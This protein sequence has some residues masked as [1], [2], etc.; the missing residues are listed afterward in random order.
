V[1]RISVLFVVLTV[2]ISTLACVTLLGEDLPAAQS[3]ADHEPPPAN[4]FVGSSPSESVSC[5]L[6]TD[7]ILKRN[8]GSPDE[9]ES[10]T[11]DF[12][13]RSENVE[14]TLVTYLVSGDTIFAPYSEDVPANLKDEQHDKPAHQ[15]IWDYFA[16]LI[17]SK[18]R[19]ILALFSI[20]TDGK[21]NILA[22]VTQT[23]NDPTLWSL[24][25][26][27]ADSQDYYYL[28]FTLVHEF[29][30]LLTLGPDQ[31][32][33]SEAIFNN[34]ED[35]NIYLKEVSA[36]PNY[37]PGEGCAN[38]DSYINKFY[39]QFWVNIYDEWNSINLEENDDVYYRRLDEFYVKY[40][41]QF[42]SDYSVTHPAED[43]AEAFA[44]F[45]F[46]PQPVGDGTAEQKVLFFYKYPE[47]V[48][49]RQNIL[50]NLCTTFPD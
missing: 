21:D 39:D 26:D 47:L 33:P 4:P 49:L 18:N 32:P 30:H 36:C 34:P 1:P 15:K 7:Q 38:S 45:V 42:L 48:K 13:N 28:T 37:F 35:N 14:T 43:I 29:A 3:P 6:I 16:A 24:E 41:D 22:A 8:S 23:S 40:Q 10:Q 44:F 9:V 19:E 2:L 11:A 17:P 20:M 50:K 31:V 25:V 5:P 46:S 27:I 12:G